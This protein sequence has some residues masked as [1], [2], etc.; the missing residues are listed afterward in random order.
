[1][2]GIICNSRNVDR[3]IEVLRAFS[4]ELGTQLIYFVPRDNIVQHAEIRKKTV[5][6]Y[7]PDSHQA[8]EYRS[9]AK[10]V[11]ENENFVIPTPMTQDR[12]EEILVEYGLLDQINDY[13][14]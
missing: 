8:N 12:L 2:G 4:H 13:R 7:E 9:L 1:L 10:A 6:D 3:E 11:E 14:I 5:I